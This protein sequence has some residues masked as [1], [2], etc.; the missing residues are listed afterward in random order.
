MSKTFDELKQG[1]EE[2]RTN[3]LP[4]SNT[5]GLVGKQFL[6]I[7][8]KQETE[9]A[10][11]LKLVTDY[12]VSTYFPNEGI[13]NSNRYLLTGAIAKCPSALKRSGQKLTFLQKNNTWVTYMFN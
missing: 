12:N 9:Q 13:E 5:A 8:E 3:V 1:A 10:D 6:D 11:R 7:I 4:D 2:I